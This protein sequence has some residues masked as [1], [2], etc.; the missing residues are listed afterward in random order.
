MLT[1]Q[2]SARHCQIFTIWFPASDS[3]VWFFICSDFVL[4]YFLYKYNL[5]AK[6]IQL[7]KDQYESALFHI[8]L[9]VILG[10]RF[11]YVI[12]YDLLSYLKNP[13]DIFAVWQGGMSFHGGALGVIIAGLL[14]CKKNNYSFYSL[15][16]PAIPLVALGLG[17]GRFGN[18]IMPNSLENPQVYRGDWC[19]QIPE[20]WPSILL[21]SMK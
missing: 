19:F 11:G 3:L 10:G 15:A 4:G 16:D 21:S 6:G 9:G 17:L 18:F 20:G 7:K 2:I 1:F 8:M 13:L 12:F 5:R 14:F